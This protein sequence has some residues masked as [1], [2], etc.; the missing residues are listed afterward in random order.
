MGKSLCASGFGGLKV[1]CWPLVRKFA[2][3]NPAEASTPSFGGEIK[4]S[5]PC[6]A[7]RHVKEPKSDVEVATFGKISRP[8]IAHSSTFRC[9]VR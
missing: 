3:S 2:S 1:S 6:C 5:V 7:L 8:F 4:P 9:W